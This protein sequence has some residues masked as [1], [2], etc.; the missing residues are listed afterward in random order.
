MTSRAWQSGSRFV[1]RL[2]RVSDLCA[3]CGMSAQP[4]V[5]FRFCR[6]C[7]APLSWDERRC[8]RYECIRCAHSEFSTRLRGDFENLISCAQDLTAALQALCPVHTSEERPQECCSACGG[9]ISTRRAR[10]E[11]CEEC[12]RAE[13][14]ALIGPP[15]IRI[16]E[17]VGY[18]HT[19]PR[20]PVREEIGSIRD[21]TFHD[22]PDCCPSRSRFLS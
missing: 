20:R 21:D 12:L 5:D 18:P 10:V 8:K 14:T 6:A 11:E 15:R 1:R 13:I 19:R 9:S 17:E 16:R 2:A 7:G 4:A 3:E 22:Y